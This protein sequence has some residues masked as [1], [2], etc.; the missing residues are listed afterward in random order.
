MQVS[1]V[2]YTPVN[3]LCTEI[4]VVYSKKQYKND[5][6]LKRRFFSRP[7]QGLFLKKEPS[8]DSEDTQ[9]KFLPKS[10]A[11]FTDILKSNQK[12]FYKSNLYKKNVNSEHMWNKA[13]S[14]Y[15]RAIFCF[16]VKHTSNEIP[17]LLCTCSK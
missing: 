13:G 14:Q 10:T 16:D 5:S 17:F 3:K 2:T 1:N 8:M 11:N 4:S 6:T 12:C 15:I 9:E 7:S